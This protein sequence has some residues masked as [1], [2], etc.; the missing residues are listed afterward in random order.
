MSAARYDLVVHERAQDELEGLDDEDRGR[1]LG[2]LEKLA[3]TRHPE[4]LR[5]VRQLTNGD[6]LMRVRAG[7][8]RAILARDGRELKLLLVGHRDNLYR[9]KL[10]VA[11]RRRSE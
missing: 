3:E 8:Q 4:Q 9:E 11:R 5:C 1:L 7:R 6:G 10:D 2:R